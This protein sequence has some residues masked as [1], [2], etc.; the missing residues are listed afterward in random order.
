MR[1]THPLWPAT[2]LC[3]DVVSITGAR[4]F[5]DFTAVAGNWKARLRLLSVASYW[6]AWHVCKAG[7]CD[8]SWERPESGDHRVPTVPPTFTSISLW[9]TSVCACSAGRSFRLPYSFAITTVGSL[10]GIQMFA[11]TKHTFY[12][13]MRKIVSALCVSVFFF[14][15]VLAFIL[16]LALADHLLFGSLFFFLLFYCS[17][18]RT[19]NAEMVDYSMGRNTY[20]PNT[21]S[22]NFNLSRFLCVHSFRLLP[23]VGCVRVRFAF[24]TGPLGIIKRSPDSVQYTVIIVVN[25]VVCYTYT[26]FADIYAG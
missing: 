13:T 7:Q 3:P 16:L 26:A 6:L 25:G 15:F 1:G 19:T 4:Q 11:R 17:H 5:D 14:G 9:Q 18:F 2:N 20:T 8:V 23:V 10:T 21:H 12:E 22:T 24:E